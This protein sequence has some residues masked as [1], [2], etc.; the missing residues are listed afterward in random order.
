MQQYDQI[1]LSEENEEDMISEIEE[2]SS[3]EDELPSE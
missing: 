2:E 3:F 1:S